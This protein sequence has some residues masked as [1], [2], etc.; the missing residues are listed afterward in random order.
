M[1]S[2]KLMNFIQKNASNRNEHY[3]AW[4]T[5]DRTFQNPKSFIISLNSMKFITKYIVCVYRLYKQAS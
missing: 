2:K 3:N 5:V 1:E 4:D